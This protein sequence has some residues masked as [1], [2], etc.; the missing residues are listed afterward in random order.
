MKLA[1]HWT[2][3]GRETLEGLGILPAAGASAATVADPQTG[4]R[5][6]ITGVDA[7]HATCPSCETRTENAA[8]ITVVEDLRLLFAC[9]SCQQLTWLPGA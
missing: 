8:F 7:G 3:A 1:G 2:H 9:P 6:S 5:L 4:V